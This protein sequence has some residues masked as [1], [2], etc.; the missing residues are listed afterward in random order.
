MMDKK[1]LDKLRT[2]LSINAKNGLDFT[3]SASIIWLIICF[4]WTMSITSF[5]KSI[6]TFY[7]GA[8][9]LPFAFLLSKI[10]KTSWKIKNNPLQPLGLW[11][12]FAQLFYF[13]LLFFTLFKMPE[14]FVMVYVIITGG[15][16]FP[17]SWFYKNKWFAI[18]SGISVVGAL[19]L[20]FKLSEKDFYLIPLFFSAI[21][22]V[23]TILLYFDFKSKKS[24][25]ITD[26]EIL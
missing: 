25:Q 4:I 2:E 18:A 1:E 15:H 3:L 24:I 6:L 21:L 13:P 11:L 26:K 16:F 9:M 5:S 10:L 19:L 22:I 23:L 12:N 20:G 8:L 14:Y 17:Y 7:T